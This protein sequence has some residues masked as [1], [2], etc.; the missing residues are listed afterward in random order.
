MK[1]EH[2]SDTVQ[3]ACGQNE[4]KTTEGMIRGIKDGNEYI[5]RGIRYAQAKRFQAAARLSS[6]EGVR[7]AISFGPACPEYST[8]LPAYEC[9]DHPYY[10]MHSEDCL[11]L[12]LR[13]GHLD[14]DTLRPVVVFFADRDF[15]TAQDVATLERQAK[16]L[17]QISS[18]VVITVYTRLNILG[19]LDLSRF[20]KPYEGS[21]NAGLLDRQIALEWIREN[22]AVFGGDGE[23]LQ[24]RT[25][26]SAYPAITLERTQEDAATMTDLLLE[27]LGLSSVPDPVTALCALSYEELADAALWVQKEMSLRCGRAIAFSPVQND[28]FLPGH[29]IVETSQGLLRGARKDSTYVFRGIRYAK[30]KRFHM[31][32]K[33]DAWDGIKDALVYGPVCPE[34]ETVNPDDNYTV[35]HVFYPQHEDCQYLNIWTQS[36]SEQAEKPVMVWLHGGGFATGSGIEHFAYNGKAMSEAEDVVVVTL[37][38]RLNVLGYLDLSAYGEEYR[39]SANLGTADLVEALRW[40]R[41]NISSFGGDPGNVTIFGQSGGGGKVAAL[42]QTP[43]AHGL[44]HKAVIQSGLAKF[45][46]REK[47][48]NPMAARILDN[49]G[50]KADDVKSLE[51]IPFHKLAAAVSAID[52]RA[53]FAFGPTQDSDFYLGDAFEAGVCDYAKTIPVLVG[54]VLG[55]FSQNFVFTAE[56]CPAPVQNKNLWSCEKTRDI[57]KK[58]F[59]SYAEEAETLQKAA[60]PD[61]PVANILFTDSMF[62]PSTFDY[63]QMRAAQGAQKTFGY[64]FSLEMPPYGGIL[65]W[66]NAEI[67]YVFHTAD[68]IEPSSIGQLTDD[69]EAI[70]CRC[71][72]NFARTGDPGWTMYT[73]TD[74]PIMYFDKTCE[75][76]N[77]DPEEKLVRF[78]QDHPVQLT[79][80]TRQQSPVGC[81]GGPQLADV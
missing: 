54:N 72:C 42:L 38:H 17:T 2:R 10:L 26:P 34:I 62:R 67:P 20:G 68:S 50:L 56:E 29:P 73:Q 48:Q 33:P 58:E 24:V 8:P 16:E 78:L 39:Y 74:H 22:A 28:L 1:L 15:Q 80:V 66:H 64:M 36:L 46:H 79:R 9:N 5:F 59:G 52:P 69:I 77:G 37:N 71:W 40:I 47:Q 65:P 4:V 49:L 45:P 11:Y 31:P 44:F 7:E 53:G 30:A 61:L 32:E 60:Y 81:L 27:R 41:D 76:R 55:E 57:L 12:N 25:L 21:G 35:P 18:A 43:S 19:Y 75:V 23:N 51:T 6:Y 14:S 13:T 3:L 70:V 63:L